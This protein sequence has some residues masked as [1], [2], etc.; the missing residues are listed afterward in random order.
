MIEASLTAAVFMVWLLPFHF[1]EKVI[2]FLY[3][4]VINCDLFHSVQVCMICLKYIQDIQTC[5]KFL[6]DLVYTARVI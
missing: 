1:D 6:N 3:V 5:V 2:I 4:N